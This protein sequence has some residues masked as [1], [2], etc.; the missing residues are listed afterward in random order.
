MTKDEAKNLKRFK[1][2]C[3]CGGYAY[4]LNGRSEKQP[5]MERCPQFKEYAEW[6]EDSHRN[7]KKNKK[8]I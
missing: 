1:N 6:W 2:I 5:H 7:D 4:E 8:N 3:N